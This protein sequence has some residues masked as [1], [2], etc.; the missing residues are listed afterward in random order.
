MNNLTNHKHST[1]LA[2]IL[3]FAL[4]LACNLTS[5]TSPTEEPIPP[6]QAPPTRKTP[7]PAATTPGDEQSSEQ[8]VGLFLNEEGA[9]EGYTLFAPL[10][11]AKT[12]LIDNTGEFVHVWENEY[13]P[14]N[15]AYLLEDGSLL[16]SANPLDKKADHPLSAGGEGGIVRRFSWEGELLWDFK[17]LNPQHRL[18][19]DIEPLPNGNVLMI[20]WEYKSKDEAIE[21]GRNPNTLKADSLWPDHIIEVK[22]TGATGGEIVWEWHVWD[23]LI[24]DHDSTKPNYGDVAAHPELIDLNFIKNPKADWN[25]TNGIDYN[26]E[27]DQILLSVHEF[28]EIWVIDHSTTT[29]EAAGH[30]GGRSGRGGDL[31][32]RWGNPQAYRAG[33]PDDQYFFG[34]HDAGWIKAG[35]PG[36]GNILV[37]N[38]G[39]GNQ[40]PNHSS[41]D[42]IQPPLLPGGGYELSPGS[43]YG[44][45]APLWTYTAENPTDFYSHNISGAQR[46]PNGNTLVCNGANG[47]FFE[48]TPEK[49]IVWLYVN[50]VTGQVIIPQGQP[51][52]EQNNHKTNTVF[53][54]RRYPTEYSGVQKLP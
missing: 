29:A 34:Q 28:G 30:S 40:E 48:V 3:I 22:P 51:I 9:F 54:I 47:I 17:Y 38:N 25:H 21:A 19:H 15:A 45:E 1:L 27:L 43:A 18:H 37:F 49:E 6:T 53:K 4:S 16:R 14:G 10:D 8:T 44:A 2:I 11:A 13:K 52:P 26:A 33:T 35:Y 23:H 32:Y 42:E 24:Q 46:L 50:P 12:F 31:L 41:V 36:E 5:Q 20:A 39:F 7:R